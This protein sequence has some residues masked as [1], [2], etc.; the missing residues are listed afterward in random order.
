M[1]IDVV[2]PCLDE[3]GALPWVLERMPPGFRAVVADNGSSD[4]SV[5]VARSY[6][7]TVV[8]ADVRGFGSACLAGL[9]AVTSEVVCFMDADASCDPGQ[10]VLLVEPVARG[11]ADLVLG[12]R[13]PTTG[14]AWPVPARLANHVLAAR[15]RRRTGL[16]LTDLGPM[17]AARTAPL[18]AL[19]VVDPRFGYPLEMVVRAAD[20]GWRVEELPVRYHPRIGR[21][22]VTGT[23]R[24]SV[25]TV[26]DMRKVLAA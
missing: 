12:R 9:A 21:S 1:V 2:L 19:G 3:A 8:H 14:G 17:R 25:R 24:G 23:V 20:A 7:A 4:G 22:K 6:G 18:R 11:A 26:I 5:E 13:V 15:L 10:L 16:A